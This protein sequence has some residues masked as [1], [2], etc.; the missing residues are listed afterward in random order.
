MHLSSP[1]FK[2]S[3]IVYKLFYTPR[4][5]L[6]LL[7]LVAW[8][9]R[10][11]QLGSMSLWW[12]ETLSWTRAQQ[13]VLTILSNQIEI[14]GLVTRDLHPPFYFL[15]LH[16]AVNLFGAT[17][18]ALRAVSSFANLLTIPLL[19]TIAKW[20]ATKGEIPYPSRIGYLTAVFAAFSPFYVWYSQEARPYTTLLLLSL[21]TVY[22]LLK[23]MDLR[24]RRRRLYFFAFCLT[25]L[26]T[27]AT[28]YL[29]FVLLPFLALIPHIFSKGTRFWLGFS[30]LL[31][32]AFG[33][34]MLI[35]P[36]AATA[37]AGSESSGPQYQ[38][39][40][41]ILRDV[42]NS[43][44]V[45][46]TANIEEVAWLDLLIVT[47]WVLGVSATIRI[48]RR[49][50]RIAI[51]LVSFLILPIL[52][53]QLGSLLRPLYLNSRYLITISPAFYIGLAFG[54]NGLAIRA[55][56]GGERKTLRYVVATCAAVSV[57]ISGAVYSLENYFFN[58]S[59]AK[60]DHKGWS[61]HL[62]ER[63]LPNDIL[64]LNAPH[65]ET[66][67][68]YYAPKNLEWI[69]L[70]TLGMTQ[71]LQEKSDLNA[72]LSAYRNNSRIW[73][74]ELHR[75]VADP[76]SHIQDL[77]M[78][79]GTPID[80]TYFSGTS[81][82]IGLQQFMRGSI[83]VNRLPENVRR[84]S[85]SFEQNLELVG[86]EMPTE[87]EAGSRSAVTLYWRLAQKSVEEV[88][89]LLRVVDENGAAW[90][91]WDAPPIG[92]FVPLRLWQP[93]TTL[94]DLQALTVDANAP[95]GKYALELNVYHGGSGEPL[96]ASTRKGI[97]VP[98]PLRLAPFQVTTAKP[99]SE[100]GLGFT[101][102]EKIVDWNVLQVLSSIWQALVR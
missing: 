56:R 102:A 23:S 7:M 82:E 84:V 72:V 90:G 24:T 15:L 12:D 25:L 21:L 35:L 60:D 44:V 63:A 18:F 98:S 37:L 41:I 48:P 91:E 51:F 55:S 19:Y 32:G 49:D 83:V 39:L 71:K 80:V 45:G 67:Y 94:R 68:K 38:P 88:R 20:L 50:A 100:T 70:P 89:I 2:Y 101:G 66:I 27:M 30:A 54:V 17:E 92:N 58:P 77:L 9:I 53:L 34:A 85:I 65:A 33:V 42:V 5:W 16:F 62:R 43:F 47:L 78:R 1:P 13:D 57:F 40:A 96:T 74:L 81:T 93:R 97:K 99:T 6:T 11:Y 79:F 95:P 29:A 52:C 64:I 31:L 26:L 46:V 69:S 3:D 86:Y 76:T 73:Y 22:T 10:L 14:Q 59:Y 28:N 61:E 75:P 8:S 36:S 4:F 87:A